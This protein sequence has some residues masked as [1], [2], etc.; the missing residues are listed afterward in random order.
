MPFSWAGSAFSGSCHGPVPSLLEQVFLGTTC[1]EQPAWNAWNKQS[2]PGLQ[3]GA[4]HRQA[5]QQP[6]YLSNRSCSVQG[7]CC[8]GRLVPGPSQSQPPVVR[9]T[10]PHKVIARSPFPRLT[11]RR[12]HPRTPRTPR[13]VLASLCQTQRASKRRREQPS[14]HRGGGL[15]R[16]QPSP[17]H[18]H[19]D[20][21]TPTCR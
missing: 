3:A 15:L 11:H 5:C 17:R 6:C 20:M 21:S 10:F 4:R 18:V 9:V 1:L 16:L 19:P 7:T 12:G 8:G 14:A 2:I 13:S